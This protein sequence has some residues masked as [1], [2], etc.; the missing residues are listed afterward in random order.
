MLNEAIEERAHRI[1]SDEFRNKR[2]SKLLEDV[3][4]DKGAVVE[5]E[6]EGSVMT[7]L[8]QK[9]EDSVALSILT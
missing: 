3:G 1:E 9:F 7:S 8:R 5:L 2:L 6:E 4:L